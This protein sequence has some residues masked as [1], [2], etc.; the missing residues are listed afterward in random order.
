MEKG[1]PDGDPFFMVF[2]KHFDIKM[3]KIEVVPLR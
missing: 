3:I 2:K 1:G